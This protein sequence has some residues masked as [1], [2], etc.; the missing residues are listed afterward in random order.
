[1]PRRIRS[2]LL[3]VDLVNPFDFEGSPKLVRQAQAIAD[4]LLAARSVFDEV[5]CPI[6]YCNDNFGQW[7]SDATAIVRSC[8]REGARGASFVRAVRPRASDYFVLKPTHSA[9]EKTPLELL[10]K[11]GKVRRVYVAGLTGDS[12]VHATVVDAHSRDFEVFV[13]RDATASETTLR[14]RRALQQ[15]VDRCAAKVIGVS[16]IKRSLLTRRATRKKKTARAGGL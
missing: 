5:G 7:R 3:L 9:F 16:A 8:T 13:V 10:L 14:N 11:W 1:M 15:L 6:I 4:S 12:C 2:A